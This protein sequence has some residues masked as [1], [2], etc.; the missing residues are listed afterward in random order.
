MKYKIRALRVGA[1]YKQGEFAKEVGI[2]RAYLRLIE[3]GKAQNINKKIMISIAQK[4]NSTVQELF[5]SDEEV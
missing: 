5:F 4:L 3:I 1:G 2:S